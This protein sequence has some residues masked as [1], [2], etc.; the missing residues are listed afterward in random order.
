MKSFLEKKLS[1]VY[2][3]EEFVS[4]LDLKLACLVLHKQF[5]HFRTERHVIV[6]SERMSQLREREAQ[7]Q[8]GLLAIHN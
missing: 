5:Q 1:F 4:D 6:P 8:A 7:A 3:E 2:L